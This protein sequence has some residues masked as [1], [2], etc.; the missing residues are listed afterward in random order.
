MR[1][2]VSVILSK[3]CGAFD[4][5]WIRRDAGVVVVVV[6]AARALESNLI[7]RS[8]FV[9]RSG[10]D[11]KITFV[12]LGLEQIFVFDDDLF[13]DFGICRLRSGGSSTIWISSTTSSVVAVVDGDGAGA[14]ASPPKPPRSVK[15]PMDKAASGAGAGEAPSSFLLLLLRSLPITFPWRLPSVLFASRSTLHPHRTVTTRRRL[16]E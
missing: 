4:K 15:R 3:K 13:F 10:G 9:L 16:S 7:A 6:V 1:L 5:R 2:G 11:V 8:C 14:G 12:Q